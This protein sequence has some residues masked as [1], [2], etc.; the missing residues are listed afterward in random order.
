MAS[1]SSTAH[2]SRFF[3]LQLLETPT[4]TKGTAFTEAERAAL[5]L[6]GR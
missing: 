1:S 3:G 5:G 4:L 2:D 6:E